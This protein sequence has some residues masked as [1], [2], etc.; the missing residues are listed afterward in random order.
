MTLGMPEKVLNAQLA[1]TQSGLFHPA[2]DVAIEICDAIMDG[3][4]INKFLDRFNHAL[5]PELAQAI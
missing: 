5:L 1:N 4:T 2:E 3:V